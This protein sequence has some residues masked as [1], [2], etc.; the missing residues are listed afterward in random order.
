[1]FYKKRIEELE[2]IICEMQID[3]ENLKENNEELFEAIL[4]ALV[5]VQ[6]GLAKKT[7][8]TPKE[9]ANNNIDQEASDAFLVK[10]NKE[11]EKMFT[12]RKEEIDK[13]IDF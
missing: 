12:K 4:P 7:K 11:L 13:F 3:I 1:M 2:D 5:G 10:V 6:V 9:F 8:T